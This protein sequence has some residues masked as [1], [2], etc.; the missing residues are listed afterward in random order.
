MNAPNSRTA[1]TPS[2]EADR[3]ISSMS[4]AI[5]MPRSNGELV[6]DAPWQSRA[7]GMAVSLSRAGYF[8]WDKFRVELARAIAQ[9]GQSGPDE[10]YLRWLDALEASMTATGAYDAEAL[11]AREA[12]YRNH[13]RDEVF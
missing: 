8:S 13:V 9:N 3:N 12:D 6:F 11:K 7:F 5:A 1:D 4:G 10:Y 2:S